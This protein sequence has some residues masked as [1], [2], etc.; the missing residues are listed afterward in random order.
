MLPRDLA[1]LRRTLALLDPIADALHETSLPAGMHAIAG[2]VGQ[3]DE[4]RADLATTLVD[5]PPAT[6]AD[7]GVIRGEASPDL[8]ECVALRGDARARIAAL[9]DASASAA[10]SSRSR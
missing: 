8:A 3:Y 4:L 6:M 7:G 9:E 10:G 1:S 2:R 5:E